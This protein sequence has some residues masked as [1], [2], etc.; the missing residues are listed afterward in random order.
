MGALYLVRHG[1]ASRYDEGLDTLSDLGVEQARAVA[2]ELRRRGVEP[3]RI[4]T[5]G[6]RRQRQTAEAL[7]G[8]APEV[9]TRWDEYDHLGVLTGHPPG[10]EPR[11]VQEAL[12]TALATWVGA[13]DGYAETWTAFRLRVGAALD[14]LDPAGTT[15]VVTSAGP[16]SAIVAALLGAPTEGWLALNRVMVNTGITTLA[17]GRRGVSL[18]SFNDHAHL[19]SFDDDAHGAGGDRRLLT[20]R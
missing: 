10:A 9:D 8:P 11:T 4:V 19:L 14:A 20:Y 16:I 17:V 5:G 13:A 2:T 12:D 7:A 1:Q 6:L 3:R 15:V 18:V